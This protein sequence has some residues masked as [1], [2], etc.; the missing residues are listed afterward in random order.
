MVIY[1]NGNSSVRGKLQDA[2]R[3]L[4]SLIH[5]LRDGMQQKYCNGGHCVGS[6]LTQSFNNLT[7]LDIYSF[8]PQHMPT[9]QYIQSL[10]YIAWSNSTVFQHKIGLTQN[11]QM[12]QLCLNVINRISQNCHISD[13]RHT[14]QY[15]IIENVPPHH[16]I[17]YLCP[18]LD[19]LKG[20]RGLGP[21]LDFAYSL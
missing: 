11:P 1:I 17:G 9:S 19:A 12:L 7:L 13:I 4:N 21:S 10:L 2:P 8:S 18:S 6:F 3:G 5:H 15:Y 14:R 16:W 20:A